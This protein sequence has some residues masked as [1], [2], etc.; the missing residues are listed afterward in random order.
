MS[1]PKTAFMRAIAS[2]CKIC[3]K[4]YLSVMC[5]C[6]NPF[7]C[8]IIAV[9]HWHAKDNFCSLQI[10]SIRG[11]SNVSGGFS[12]I[13]QNR[14][15]CLRITI[16]SLNRLKRINTRLITM[17]IYNTRWEEKDKKKRIP[18]ETYGTYPWIG[19]QIEWNE[20][21]AGTIIVIGACNFGAG[22]INLF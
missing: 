20:F 8:K 7:F 13:L 10:Y 4:D 11:G 9:N 12:F 21:Y 19:F 5:Y 14:H 16:P 18:L 2:I 6:S 1:W 22:V 3:D 17:E 15:T